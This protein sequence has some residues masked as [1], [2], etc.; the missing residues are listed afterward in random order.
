MLLLGV[1]T[2]WWWDRGSGWG[3]KTRAV[4]VLGLLLVGEGHCLGRQTCCLVALML[5]YYW[6]LHNLGGQQADWLAQVVY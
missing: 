1:G 5:N 4:A 6:G 2:R 3:G